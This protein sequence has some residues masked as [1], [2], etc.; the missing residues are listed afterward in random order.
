MSFTQKS[1]W[2]IP[3]VELDHVRLQLMNRGK[4]RF[5]QSADLR[6]AFI[7]FQTVACPNSVSRN[8]IQLLCQKGL[9]AFVAIFKD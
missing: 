3:G 8:M 7:H 2:N 4:K 6:D 1:Q 5:C 9:S